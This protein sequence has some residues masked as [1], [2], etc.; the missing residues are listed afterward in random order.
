MDALTLA[1][2]AVTEFNDVYPETL[3]SWARTYIPEPLEVSWSVDDGGW[4]SRASVTLSMGG[5]VPAAPSEGR[6]N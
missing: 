4:Y 2:S 3:A 5:S 6:A 1:C